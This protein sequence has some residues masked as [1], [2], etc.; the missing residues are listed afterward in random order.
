M[1]T[2]GYDKL[3]MLW[4]PAEVRPVDIGKRLDGQ[5]DATLNAI[6]LAGHDG[7]VRAV[8][9]SPNGKLALS[10]SEDNT[11]RVWDIATGEGV[12]TLRGHGSS[13]RSCVFSPDGQWVLSGGDDESVRLWNVQGYQEVRVLHA[14]VFSGHDD[15]VLSARFSR[16]GQKIVTASRDRTAS[17]WNAETGQPLRRFQEGHEFLVSG[18]V[19]YPDGQ[20]LATGAGDNSVRVWDLTAGTQTAMMTPTGRIGTLAVSPDGKWLATGSIGSAIKLWNAATGEALGSLTGHD[21]EVSA[22]RFSPRGDQLASGDSQGHVR[23]WKLENRGGQQPGSTGW[24]FDRELVGHNGSINTIRYTPDGLRL[25]TASGDHSCGA[26]G[27]GER[28][29]TSASGA[30]ARRLGV[31]A[32]CFGRRQARRNNLRRWCCPLVA[33][34]R[35]HADRGGEIGWQAVQFGRI[36]ARWQHGRAG[37]LRR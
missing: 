32:R 4:N 22:L 9:F 3:V 34:G 23:L 24:S 18:A 8:A 6:P 11:I 14:T 5:P 17:L 25:L 15:A 7:P 33:T 26:V 28:R 36:L 20:H 27:S 10:G 12:K 31:V 35:C 21:A 2:G 13:V 37:I 19:F 30:Q 1:A 29:R 16:D